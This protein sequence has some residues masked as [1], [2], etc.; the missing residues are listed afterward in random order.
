MSDPFVL[1]GRPHWKFDHKFTE[2]NKRLYEAYTFED[3]IKLT[4]IEKWLP[5]VVS[6]LPDMKSKWL[7]HIK[8]WNDNEIKE[9][10]KLGKPVPNTQTGENERIKSNNSI[11]GLTADKTI[12]YSGISFLFIVIPYHSIKSSFNEIEAR[13]IN[14]LCYF[15]KVS[16]PFEADEDISVYLRNYE[17]YDRVYGSSA[18]WLT[19]IVYERINGLSHLIDG[20]PCQ[21]AS[22][23]HETS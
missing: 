12:A 5:T 17:T 19:Y 1:K 6:F 21:L 9:R 20:E 7:K 15:N 18:W 16:V 14:R 3:L 2:F 8:K 4:Q 22:S 13:Y 11:D 23:V 10:Q